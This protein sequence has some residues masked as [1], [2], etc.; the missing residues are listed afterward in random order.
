MSGAEMPGAELSSAETVAPNQRRQIGGGETYTTPI[1][2]SPLLHIVMNSS[3]ISANIPSIFSYKPRNKLT[4]A[5]A[6]N[7]PPADFGCKIIHLYIAGN[8]HCITGSGDNHPQWQPNGNCCIYIHIVL[9][10]SMLLHPYP[11]CYIRIVISILLKA[12]TIFL[13]LY[14]YC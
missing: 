13:Y 9:S 1:L 6:I 5:G 4:S 3:Q 12:I 2:L 11:Y 10:I 14:P 8:K 7:L